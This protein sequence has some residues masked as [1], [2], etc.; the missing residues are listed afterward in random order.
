MAHRTGDERPP[1]WKSALL[2]AR[3]WLIFY[4]AWL[5]FVAKM[6]KA[7]LLVGVPVA[8]LGATASQIVWEK[9]L[10]RFVPRLRWIAQGWRLPIYMFT[11]TWEILVVLA[12]HLFTRKKADSLLYAVPYESPGD[13]DDATMIEA[14]AIGY[15]TMTPNFVVVGIDHER[16]LML[17]HQ[18]AQSDVLEMTKR[19]GAR[20]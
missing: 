8:A 18:L 19:L 4:G 11:G 1:R 10:A 15:T 17:Y 5:L 2:W 13:E 9:K 12:R 16:K 7:E 3:Q 14:L 6:E 20:P